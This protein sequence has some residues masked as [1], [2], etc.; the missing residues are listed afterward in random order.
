MPYSVEGKIVIAISSSAL[1]D[2]AE[3]D[4]IFREQGLI[5]YK[6]HQKKKIDVPFMKEMTQTDG[7]RKH[8]HLDKQ[9]KQLNNMM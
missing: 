8:Q 4:A 7:C 1:F 9:L 3:S 2:M 5:A 6:E